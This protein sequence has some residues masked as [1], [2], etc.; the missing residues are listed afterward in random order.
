MLRFILTENFGNMQTKKM[1]ACY[2]FRILT[3][4]LSNVT[5]SYECVKSRARHEC[6]CKCTTVCRKLCFKKSSKATKAKKANED[7]KGQHS[8]KP[9]VSL[10]SSLFNVKSSTNV[11]TILKKYVFKKLEIFIFIT[12]IF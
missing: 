5:Q 6:T 2:F 3:I 8:P 12:Q 1:H 9:Q 11:N 7:Q 4:S 10:L